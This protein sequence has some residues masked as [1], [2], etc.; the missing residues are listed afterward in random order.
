METGIV[1]QLLAF[2][3]Q[4]GECVGLLS[5]FRIE[6]LKTRASG[7]RLGDRLGI[8]VGEQPS[9]QAGPHVAMR[10]ALGKIPKL[11]RIACEVEELRREALPF[12]VFPAPGADHP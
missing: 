6:R 4:S 12:D 11:V 8:P 7:A 9:F 1:V 2:S 5:D 10:R 3:K